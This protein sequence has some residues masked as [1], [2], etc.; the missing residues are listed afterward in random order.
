MKNEI[1]D[2]NPGGQ[3]L[4]KARLDAGLT[5][6]E[7]AEK[8]GVHINQIQRFE[9]GERRMASAEAKTFMAIADALG[10]DPHCLL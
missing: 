10:L 7:L 1:F 4:K 8:A 5:Q 6:K 3:T 9:K 2:C